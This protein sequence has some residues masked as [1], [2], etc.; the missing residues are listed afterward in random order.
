MD[1]VDLVPDLVRHV[2]IL[3]VPAATLPEAIGRFAVGLPVLQVRQE[4][5][6]VLSQVDERPVRDGFLE[7]VQE[8]GQALRGVAG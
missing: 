4:R 8:L 2:E 7:R 5:R 3:V 1:I 6:R